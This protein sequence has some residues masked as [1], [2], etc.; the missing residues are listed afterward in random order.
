MRYKSIKLINYIGIYNGLK[1]NE[2]YI[3][4]TKCKHNTILIKGDNGSGKSTLYNAL[5]PLPDSNDFFIPGLPAS[6]EIEIYDNEALY[7]LRFIHGIKNN[8]D[9]EV[10]KAYI[11]KVLPNGMQHDMNPNGNVSS[12]KDIIYEE[13]RLDS[14]FVALSQLSNED[15]GLADKKPDRKS[16]V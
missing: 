15:K 12:F 9:R 11:Y 8:G 10:T 7:F 14:N 5:N 13:F 2:I 3:D 16:V 4:F 1:L 6:K